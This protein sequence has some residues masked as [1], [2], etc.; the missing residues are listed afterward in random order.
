MKVNKLFFVP[1]ILFCNS[2]QSQVI[3]KQFL[4]TN[5]LMDINNTTAL[6]PIAY[7]TEYTSNAFIPDMVTP[8]NINRDVYFVAK[9][10]GLRFN[11]GSGSQYQDYSVSIYFKFNPFQPAS[12]GYARILDVK[13]NTVD[14]GIYRRGNNL[15]FYP[16]G[17]VGTDLLINS[18]TE[19]VLL[20]L[21]RNGTTGLVKVYI[22][23]LP[24][25][26]YNDAGGAYQLTSSGNFIFIKDDVPVPHE[27]SPTNLAYIRV[28]NT[29]LSDQNVLDMYNGICGS[30]LGTQEAGHSNNELQIYPNPVKDI[31]K[32]KLGNNLKSESIDMYDV[33]GK[34]LTSI[35]N[36]KN[37]NEIN[38]SDYPKGNY[39]LK[40]KASNGKTYIQKIIK[41]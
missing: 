14:S 26:T 4:L 9:N 32:F 25:S 21:T 29:L 41:K 17:D 24:A 7:N 31:L 20:T 16:N 35:S 18:G 12:N 1:F 40:V 33:S 38:I 13:D 30:I 5:D 27:Q 28:T 39:I 6:V 8:C 37:I 22:N 3:D 10:A 34:I 2:I 23:G 19:Y 11:A 36:A 15:N